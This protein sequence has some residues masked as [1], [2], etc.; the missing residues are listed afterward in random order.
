MLPTS[1]H[2]LLLKNCK[3]QQAQ[4]TQQQ[5]QQQQQFLQE[6]ETWKAA[7]TQKFLEKA[8]EWK[9]PKTYRVKGR[10]GYGLYA[11]E[12]ASSES[13]SNAPPTNSCRIQIHDHRFQLMAWK[14]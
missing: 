6:A 7:E 4:Q 8:P 10:R 9:D 13:F 11:G 12:S 14:G 2:A 1:R 5:Y 3:Q